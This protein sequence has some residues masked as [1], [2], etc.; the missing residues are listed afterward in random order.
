MADHPASYYTYPEKLLHVA[1]LTVRQTHR[2]RGIGEA[3]LGRAEEIAREFGASRLTL[4][5]YL[6]NDGAVRFYERVGFDPLKY[7]MSKS[8]TE[9]QA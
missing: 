8:I 7:L 2:R 4:E 5:V 9:D 6:F 3:L 1:V